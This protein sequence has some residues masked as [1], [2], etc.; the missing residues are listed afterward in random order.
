MIMQDDRTEAQRKTHTLAIGGTDR[1]MSG[2]GL[3]K[4]GSF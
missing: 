3:A 4:G 2:W 1:F